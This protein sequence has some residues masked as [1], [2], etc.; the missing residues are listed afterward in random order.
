MTN[1]LRSTPH[2]RDAATKAEWSPA[3]HEHVRVSRRIDRPEAE[4]ER[5]LR[6]EPDRLVRVAYG[7]DATA[8]ATV[9]SLPLFGSLDAP[10]VPV[11]VEFL[12]PRPPRSAAIISLKWQATFLNR[13]F[14]VLEADIAVL[15]GPELAGLE[16]NGTYL[17]PLGIAGLV[18]D[19]FVGRRI[20]TAAAVGFVDALATA[21]ELDDTAKGAA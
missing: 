3:I 8:A 19:R 13:Y 10:R 18:F 14:P 7:V 11:R 5:M 15:H 2:D 6:I 20:A 9:I 16:L 12:T 21:I 1:T 4:V 17:P